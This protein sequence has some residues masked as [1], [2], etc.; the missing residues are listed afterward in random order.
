MF[1]DTDIVL[2]EKS[3][4]KIHG[5][6][7]GSGGDKGSSGGC[8]VGLGRRNSEAKPPLGTRNRQNNCFE[9]PRIWV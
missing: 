8:Q 6:S 3:S 2:G 9:A 7:L 5:K 4:E 1:D